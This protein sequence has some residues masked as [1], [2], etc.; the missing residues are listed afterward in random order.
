LEYFVSRLIFQVKF[1]IYDVDEFKEDESDKKD[2]I[3]HIIIPL[4][5]IVCAHNQTVTKDI[6]EARYNY[7]F[8]RVLA[9]LLETVKISK[10]L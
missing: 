5:E 6:I 3:G 8:F 2:F 7:F 9:R 1:E 4:H 10:V